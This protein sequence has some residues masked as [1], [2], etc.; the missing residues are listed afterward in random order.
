MSRDRDGGPSP[1]PV[2]VRP[3]GV[4]PGAPGAGGERRARV[5]D[6]GGLLGV[7][8]AAGGLAAV[9]AVL[10]GAV[11]WGL[12]VRSL[13]AL[14]VLAVVHGGLVA[15]AAPRVGTA[16][17]IVL[18]VV[19]GLA[20]AGIAVWLSGVVD[21]FALRW[22]VAAAPALAW[23]HPSARAAWW[24]GA[25][26]GDWRD[27]IGHHGPALWG[28]AV[29]WALAARALAGYYSPVGDG[30]P[31]RQFYVDLPWH[32]ALTAEALDRAPT[33]YPWIPDVGIGYSWLFFGTLGLLGNLSGATAAQLVLSV[34]PALLALV[35]PAALVACTWVAGRSRLAA[36]LAPVVFSLARAPLFGHTEGVQITPQW[37]LINRDATNAMVLAV[38]LLLVV[39]RQHTAGRAEPARRPAA[40]PFL[41][42]VFLIAFAAAGSRGGAVVPILGAA[43]LSWLLSLRNGDERRDTTWSLSVIGLAVVCAT[44]AVTR[45]SG[46]F[47]VDPLSFLPVQVAAWGPIPVATL[48]SLVVMLA[49][50]GAV[51]LVGRWL[52][53]ARPAVP[54]L[55]GAAL[56][57]IV[58]LTL[59]G[60]PSFSQLYFFHAGW[61]V[62]V[63]GLALVLAVAVG[64]LGPLV[65]LVLAVGVLAAQVLLDPPDLL[66]PTPWPIRLAVVAVLA[67]LVIGGLTAALARVHGWRRTTALTLPV[68][69]LALQPW[70]LPEVVHPAAVVTAAPTQGSV[71][72]GQLALLAELRE[73]SDPDD[74]V[75]TNKH[76]LGGTVAT[77]TCDARWFTVAAFA[78]RRVLVEGWSYD[79]TWT[80][81]GNDNLEPYWD[82]A[83]LRANDGFIADPGPATCRVLRDAGVRWIFVDHREPWSP[84]I[85]DFAEPVG[86]VEDAS[87][88]RLDEECA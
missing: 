16:V 51:A 24:P 52:P 62:I 71:S 54:V 74:L 14:A 60:H 59:F 50:T 31:F 53:P 11:G 70:A 2:A 21:W 12:A 78:E 66:P 76:C 4:A 43:G 1:F 35:V 13:A 25:A 80:S 82:P 19:L 42:V 32:I 55:A 34:G 87:L 30:G 72:D 27:R 17:R 38:V 39:R 7:V 40:A 18:S 49:M 73:R 58:G 3:P 33:V 28:L 23:L 61:P 41:L 26:A 88:Y 69:L 56:A 9:L 36:G 57:G 84:R 29:A 46:S 15:L 47:R 68:L 86:A 77:G 10:A 81:S 37:V 45:S 63:V 79:Y 83:L 64:A 67:L 48:A 75:A 8:A 44:V 6:L 85:A 20:T 5:R 65:L 22:F